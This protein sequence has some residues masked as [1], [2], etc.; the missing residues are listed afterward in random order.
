MPRLQT[1]GAM[2]AATAIVAV[3]LVPRPTGSDRPRPWRSMTAMT[4]HGPISAQNAR[5]AVVEAETP[6][7][8]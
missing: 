8:P 6:S 3:F 7:R 1:I 5:I 2:I 4:S